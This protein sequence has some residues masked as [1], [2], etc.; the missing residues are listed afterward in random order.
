MTTN[1]HTSYHPTAG[2]VGKQN[3]VQFSERVTPKW[4][5]SLQDLLRL[6]C[7]TSPYEKSNHLQKKNKNT[8]N[9][10]WLGKETRKERE[11]KTRGEEINSRAASSRQHR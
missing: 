7:P 1:L 6:E 8:K 5:K 3:D 4:K 10:S 2:I 9:K 11:E